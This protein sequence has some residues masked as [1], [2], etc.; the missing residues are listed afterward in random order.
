MSSQSIQDSIRGQKNNQVNFH[1]NNIVG[2][3]LNFYNTYEAVRN[4]PNVKQM[5]TD[6]VD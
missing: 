3:T 1:L 6:I 4:V 2:H 5:S